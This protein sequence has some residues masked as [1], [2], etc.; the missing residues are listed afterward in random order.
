MDPHST[1]LDY[2]VRNNASV[3]AA[4]I[5]Y[6]T[7]P[8]TLIIYQH[9][10]RTTDPIKIPTMLAKLPRRYLTG[11]RLQIL[12]APATNQRPE[13]DNQICYDEPIP[14][15]T[16]IQPAYQPWLGTAGAPVLTNTPDTGPIWAILSCAHVLCPHIPRAGHPI[17]QPDQAHP[18]CAHLTDWRIP[19][20]VTDN[21]TDCAIADTLIDGYHTIDSTILHCGQPTPGWR[22]AIEG[23]EVIKSGRTT[24]RTTARCL[25]SA[26][27]IQ[28]DYHDH[29]CT[30]HDQ[31]LYTSDEAPFGAPG[32]SGSAV[33]HKDTNKLTGLLFAGGAE[34]TAANPIRHVAAELQLKPSFP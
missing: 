16:Q 6:K 7:D 3:T 11:S 27:T 2:I 32:D 20:P 22:N 13:N 5:D 24:G 12:I 30:F 17:H 29:T 34:I 31:D 18:A 1:Q 19:D 9:A 33:L 21:L 25:A 15:G 10:H 28:V 8:P 26:A 23:D 14:L 4:W